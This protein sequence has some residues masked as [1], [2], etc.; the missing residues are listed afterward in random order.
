METWDKGGIRIMAEGAT[1]G[2][3]LIRM[4]HLPPEHSVPIAPLVTGPPPS[5]T[6]NVPFV[7]PPVIVLNLDP[8]VTVLDRLTEEVHTLRAELA[9]RSVEGRWRRVKA[10]IRAW[11]QG[12]RHGR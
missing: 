6:T 2:P 3:A 5:S 1:L 11:W 8:I 10:A 4:S 9:A 12:V 7:E